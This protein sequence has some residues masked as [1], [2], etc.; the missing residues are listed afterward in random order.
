MLCVWA[1]LCGRACELF[2]VR[3]ETGGKRVFEICRFLQFASFLC[4]ESKRQEE[5]CCS[6]VTGKTSTPARIAG[7]R[8]DYDLTQ[9]HHS[10]KHPSN[11][12]RHRQQ[13]SLKCQTGYSFTPEDEM[14]RRFHSGMIKL[15]FLIYIFYKSNRKL[16]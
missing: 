2:D 12:Q 6:R 10:N 8:S 5:S 9:T 11:K 13:R 15:L 4:S 3:D 1:N 16:H 7:T 14:Q